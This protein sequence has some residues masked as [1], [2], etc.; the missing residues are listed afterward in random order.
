GIMFAVEDATIAATYMMLAAHA[1]RLHTCWVGAFDDGEVKGILDLPAHIRPVALL[2]V[3]RG[4]AP[5][6]GPE[7]MDPEGHAH[8]DIW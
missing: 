4:E 5:S 1:R 3:G 7:R 6:R 8:Y 2:C